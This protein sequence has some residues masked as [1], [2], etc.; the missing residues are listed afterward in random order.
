MDEIHLGSLPWVV[1]VPTPQGPPT[2]RGAGGSRFPSSPVSCDLGKGK[3]PSP[4]LPKSRNS[5]SLW[6]GKHGCRKRRSQMKRQELAAGSKPARCFRRDSVGGGGVVMSRGQWGFLSTTRTSKGH[7]GP[8]PAS[9]HAHSESLLAESSS[10]LRNTFPPLKER[11]WDF[12]CRVL[13]QAPYCGLL[14]RSGFNVLMA[15]NVHPE[16]GR[17]LI[18]ASPFFSRKSFA[19]PVAFYSTF[20]SPSFSPVSSLSHSA[21]ADT[22]AGQKSLTD[23]HYYR[24]EISPSRHPNRLTSIPSPGPPEDNEARIAPE[25]SILG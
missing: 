5:Y 25:F 14:F 7:L 13:F 2:P 20:L 16:D 19:R 12:G 3:T 8:P 1:L 10:I 15:C 4:S 17:P 22:R 21:I 11:P 23:S 18:T 6:R 9:G 24:R